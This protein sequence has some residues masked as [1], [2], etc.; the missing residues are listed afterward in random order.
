MDIVLDKRKMLVC[1]ILVAAILAALNIVSQ[2]R[3][4]GF[5]YQ[6]DYGN[7]PEWIEYPF[8]AVTIL[9]APIPIL[10]A[11]LD[12]HI[13]RMPDSWYYIGEVVNS[14]VWANVVLY[15]FLKIRFVKKSFFQWVR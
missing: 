12:A 5:A 13:L 9:V 11:Q 6:M 7:A 14:I 15:L 10:L 4:L 3:L 1:W 8:I 2:A